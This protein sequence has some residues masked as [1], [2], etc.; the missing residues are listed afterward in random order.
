MLPPISTVV[1]IELVR[2]GGSLAA[3]VIGANGATYRLHFQLISSC[4]DDGQYIRHG[5]ERPVIF[6]S[7]RFHFGEGRVACESLNTVEISWQHALVFL[8]Q[9]RGYV[10]HDRNFTWLEAMEEVAETEGLLPEHFQ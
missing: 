9:L 7:F 5:Y 3:T 8:H 4:S 10:R 6:E 2:D 1:D